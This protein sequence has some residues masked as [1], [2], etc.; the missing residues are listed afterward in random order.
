MD[1]RRTVSSEPSGVPGSSRWRC[2]Q[3][4]SL[5][6]KSRTSPAYWLIDMTTAGRSQQLL[7]LCD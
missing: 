5:A 1:Q 4:M 2:T 3:T 7:S 6:D